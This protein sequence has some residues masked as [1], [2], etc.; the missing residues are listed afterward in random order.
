MN[1]VYNLL[2]IHCKNAESQITGNIIVVRTFTILSFV[3]MIPRVLEE[4][5]VAVLM[6]ISKSLT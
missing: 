2:I 1:K 3:T 4:S 6:T 5:T